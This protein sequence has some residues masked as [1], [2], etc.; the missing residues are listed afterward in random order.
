MCNAET[1]EYPSSYGISPMLLL[2]KSSN[3]IPGIAEMKA[4]IVSRRL[5][6]R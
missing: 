3:L 2:E 1:K 4:G 5:L 6:L